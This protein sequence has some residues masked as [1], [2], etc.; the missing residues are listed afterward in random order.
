MLSTGVL[1]SPLEYLHPGHLEKWK[2]KYGVTDFEGVMSNLF[3]NRTSP[4]GWFGVKAHWTQFEPIA[5]TQSHLQAIAFSKYI[6]IF[7]S[8]SIAQ[9]ISLVIARKTSAWISFHQ[10][11][12]QPKYDFRAI[13]GALAE[14]EEQNGKWDTFFERNGIQPL[15]IEY[16]ALSELPEEA[17]NNI[18]SYFDLKIESQ[19]PGPVPERQSTELNSIW[20]RRYLEDLGAASKSRRWY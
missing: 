6:R 16:E 2:M 13:Q 14:I 1:G 17:L 4:T 11:Q 20:K 5:N 8:D 10:V 3:K 19:K 15:M 9:A 12:K 18:L 7:R